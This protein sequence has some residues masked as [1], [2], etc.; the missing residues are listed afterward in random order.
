MAY[1]IRLLSICFLISSSAVVYSS[2]SSDGNYRFISIVAVL[3]VQWSHNGIFQCLYRIKAHKSTRP[4]RW[5]FSGPL[6][7]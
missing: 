3:V 7:I 4:L 2:D 5:I 6:I 1:V